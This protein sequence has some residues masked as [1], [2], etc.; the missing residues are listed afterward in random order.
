MTNDIILMIQDK[1]FYE[2]GSL[3]YPDHWVEEFFGDTIVVNGK[4][5]P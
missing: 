1:T 4:I 3:Y 2:N 5:W